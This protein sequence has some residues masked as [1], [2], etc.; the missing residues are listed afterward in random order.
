MDETHGAPVEPTPATKVRI[1]EE[2]VELLKLKDEDGVAV[3]ARI[4]RLSAPAMLAMRRSMPLA[5]ELSKVPK[6]EKRLAVVRKMSPAQEQAMAIEW[7]ASARDVAIAGVVEPRFS[8]D[9]ADGTVPVWVLG[10]DDLALLY[11]RIG[12]LSDFMTGKA[13]ASEKEKGN[14]GEV[15]RD[16]GTFPRDDAGG[17]AASA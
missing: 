4:R 9:G 17:G 6:G 11:E 16:L 14:G 1:P 12:I 7:E 2:V 15:A 13:G 3:R 10:E 8:Q 5:L